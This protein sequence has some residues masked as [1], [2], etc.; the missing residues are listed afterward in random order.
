MVFQ[1]IDFIV[2]ISFPAMTPTRFVHLHQIKDVLDLFWK[3]LG[4]LGKYII[5]FEEKPP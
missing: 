5:A 2:A 1:L 3:N 4:P